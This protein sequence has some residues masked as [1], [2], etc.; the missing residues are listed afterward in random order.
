MG[1][2]ASG[3]GK[4]AGD[5]AEKNREKGSARIKEDRSI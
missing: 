4:L 3:Q 2:W 1:F 5:V